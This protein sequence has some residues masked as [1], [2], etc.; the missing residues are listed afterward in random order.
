MAGKVMAG[1][2]EDEGRG[3]DCCGDADSIATGAR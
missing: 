3:I 1:S 2:R